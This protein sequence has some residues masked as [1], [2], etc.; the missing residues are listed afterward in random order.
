MR[1]V[2]LIRRSAARNMM[3]MVMTILTVPEIYS[4][5]VFVNLH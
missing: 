3:L 5:T 2:G 1:Q 4:I